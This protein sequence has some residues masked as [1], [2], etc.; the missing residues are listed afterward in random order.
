MARCSSVRPPPL[1]R[2]DTT[3]VARHVT[4]HLEDGE[5]IALDGR[6][7]DPALLTRGLLETVI[8]RA[9][10]VQGDWPQD[11]VLTYPLFPPGGSPALLDRVGQAAVGGALL[12]PN[13]VAAVAKLA[14]DVEIAVGTTVAVLDLGG[15]T[16]E[17]TIVRRSHDGFDVVGPPGGL[18]DLGG[19]EFDD[20]VFARV[21]AALGHVLQE[22]PRDDAEGMAALRRLRVA[23]RAAKEWLS[24]SPDTTVEVALPQLSTWVP[25]RRADLESDIRPALMAA[26]DAVAQT[27]AAAELAPPDVHV[28]LLVG[29]SSR[30][31]LFGEL[32]ASRLGLPVVADPFP[33][34]TVA[35]GAALFGRD[36]PPPPPPAGVAATGDDPGTGSREAGGTRPGDD[37]GALAAW[38]ADRAGGPT[39]VPASA[40]G[41]GLTAPSD[42]LPEGPPPGYAPTDAHTWDGT[43][44]DGNEWD[45]NEDD[46]GEWDRAGRDDA[47]WDATEGDVTTWSATDD[48]AWEPQWDGAGHDDP[49]H[50][51]E[52][53]GGE[54]TEA[55]GD[56]SDTTAA[57]RRTGAPARPPARPICGDHHRGVAAGDGP[58][59]TVTTTSRK[60]SPVRTRARAPTPA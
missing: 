27:I 37:V 56:W 1:A 44:W 60:L 41:P 3:L 38:F 11:V 49:V 5:P 39:Q 9:R 14:H 21:D 6:P 54:W 16:F 57:R 26:V 59:V 8:D 50:A 47:Q 55:V 28:A 33:E 12:I 2:Y 52:W 34:L 32:V 36:G 17:V 4:S 58:T 25:I 29:G 18:A 53:H 43:Q 40:L 22:V 13:P 31:P 20:A 7:H 30:I 24:S 15:G 51:A 35:L 23:C 46:G 10:R 19:V 42:N 48:D 45:G